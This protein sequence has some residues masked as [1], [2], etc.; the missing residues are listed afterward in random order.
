VTAHLS[1]SVGPVGTSYR[2][3]EVQVTWVGDPDA[4]ESVVLRFRVAA[5]RALGY[6]RRRPP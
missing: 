4:V 1:T 2:L 5:F 3:T 6:R